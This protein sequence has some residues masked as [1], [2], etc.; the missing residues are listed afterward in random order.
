M[1]SSDITFKDL[2]NVYDIYK[3]RLAHGESPEGLLQEVITDYFGITDN[4]FYELFEGKSKK[5]E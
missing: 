2:D 5:E 4:E 1:I 3:R